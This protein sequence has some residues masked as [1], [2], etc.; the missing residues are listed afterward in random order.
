MIKFI[1]ISAYEVFMKKITK[2]EYQKKNKNRVNIYLDESFSFGIDLNIMIKYSLTKNM[3]LSDEFIE[4]I[5]KSEEEIN[6]YNYG[7]TVLS[8]SL[9]SEKQLKAKMLDKGYDNELIERVIEKLKSQR[10]IDDV[11]YCEALVN[12]RI[13]G[14]KYGKRRIV[15]E[16]YEKGIDR[17]TT[18][19][20]LNEI[21]DEEEFERAYEL[22]MKK[23][24]SIK[25]EDTLKKSSKLSNFLIYRGF[26]YETVKKVVER[27]LKL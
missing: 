26:D 14:S 12:T 23:M 4:D 18:D 19:N 2:I 24:K 7:L 27:I 3:E 21:S 10:Y 16:L 25:D 17:E 15:Q 8:R 5:L 11:Y 13:N 6:V 20:K 1:K 9:K 22:A